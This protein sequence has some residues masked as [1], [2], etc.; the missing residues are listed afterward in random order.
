M[1]SSSSIIITLSEPIIR[2]YR[3][4]NKIYYDDD[5]YTYSIQLKKGGVFMKHFNLYN[6]RE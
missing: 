2:F 1:T 6:N 5:R 4:E 3:P